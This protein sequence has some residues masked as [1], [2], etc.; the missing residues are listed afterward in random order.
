MF[1][2][3]TLL[4]QSTVRL[5]NLW[6]RPQVHVLFGE[7]RLSFKIK[8]IDRTLQIL[9]DI[10]NRT[11]G[12]SSGL[13]TNR[14][15][16]IEL[17]ADRQE[18]RGRF[19]RMMHQAV[20]TFLLSAGQAEVRHGRK[21]LHSVIMEVQPVRQDDMMARIKFFDPKKHRLIYSGTMPVDMY[22]RD[23]GID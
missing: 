16:S 8:D 15:Y 5:H 13:D 11:W 3:G 10:G 9:A 18:Y 2:S 12:P 7:Y 23:I 4:A 17:Y 19:E 1:F 6:A 21:R 14:Q 22:N 20:A